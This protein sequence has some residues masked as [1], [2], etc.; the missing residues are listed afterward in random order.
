MKF[1]YQTFE[2]YDLPLYQKL[3]IV[4]LK[5]KGHLS[6]DLKLNAISQVD[7]NQIVTLHSR[8][9]LLQDFDVSL[10]VS[11]IQITRLCRRQ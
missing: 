2:Y 11:E 7:S 5:K 4:T 10:R 6:T 1:Y 9:R 3:H 8:V